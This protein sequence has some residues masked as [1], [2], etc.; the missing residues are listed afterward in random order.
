MKKA[1]CPR[2]APSTFFH[3]FSFFFLFC[4]L[5]CS[6][7]RLCTWENQACKEVNGPLCM[8]TWTHARAHT[9]THIPQ[10]ISVAAPKSLAPQPVPGAVTQAGSFWDGKSW[11]GGNYLQVLIEVKLS[12]GEPEEQSRELRS[13]SMLW[14]WIIPSPTAPE[15]SADN[16]EKVCRFPS[17]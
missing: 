14:L 11:E 13:L 16:R 12:P 15:K 8:C 9:D 3:C 2:K 17:L 10:V 5:P 1:K 6:R 4:V 7:H